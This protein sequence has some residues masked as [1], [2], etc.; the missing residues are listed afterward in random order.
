MTNEP[1][2]HV[3]RAQLPWRTDELTECGRELNDV[4]SYIT[5]DQLIA[6]VKEHGQQRTAFTVCMTCWSTASSHRYDWNSDPIATI[7]R[8]AS[9][10]GGSYGH[11]SPSPERAH[12]VAELRAITALIDAHRDEFDGYI[13]GLAATV[14][15]STAK[16]SRR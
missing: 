13:T 16:R 6:R 10:C 11:A 12:L 7:A 5:R 8:E 2:D 14:S 1:R 4:A 9:R 3:I 15:L